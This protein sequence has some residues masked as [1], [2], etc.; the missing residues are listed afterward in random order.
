[1]KPRKT[2]K[3]GNA[4]I[5]PDYVRIVSQTI[6]QFPDLQQDVASL[7]AQDAEYYIRDLIHLAKKH[8]RHSTKFCLSVQHILLA[9]SATAREQPSF[10][11][12]ASLIPPKFQSVVACPGL[13]IYKDTVVPL[14]PI[15]LQPLPPPTTPVH[16]SQSTLVVP[17]CSYVISPKISTQ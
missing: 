11:V 10:G 14:D 13:Y 6:P 9:H 4:A 12:A 2:I 17:T 3:R 16:I 7:L 8:M 5:T 15:L 1:M